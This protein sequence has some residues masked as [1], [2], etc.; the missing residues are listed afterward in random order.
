MDLLYQLPRDQERC[1]VLGGVGG[2]LWWIG[3]GLWW[4]GEGSS[5]FKFKFTF[6]DLG[7]HVEVLQVEGLV[8]EGEEVIDDV[9][10]R[11]W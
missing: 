7:E 1:Q 5:D 2:G 4:V 6:K 11:R 8:K 3:G 9:E 10:L